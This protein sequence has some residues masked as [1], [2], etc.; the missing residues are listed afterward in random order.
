MVFFLDFMGKIVTFV[1]FHD[2]C[3]FYSNFKSLLRALLN[4]KQIDAEFLVQKGQ[5]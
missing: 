4:I 5:T 1:W 2:Q 3:V